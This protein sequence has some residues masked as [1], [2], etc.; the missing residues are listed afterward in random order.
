MASF[1]K[2]V[3]KKEIIISYISTK[4]MVVDGMTKPLPPQKFK[5]FKAMLGMTQ[6]KVGM[7][8]LRTRMVE[9]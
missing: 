2:K 9:R 8:T 5:V 6:T 1:L 7:M 3:L 4:E